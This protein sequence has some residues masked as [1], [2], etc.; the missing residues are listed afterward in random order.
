MANSFKRPL[1]TK[2]P[3]APPELQVSSEGDLV[4]RFD[5]SFRSTLRTKSLL[6]RLQPLAQQ[7]KLGAL[8]AIRFAFG[9]GTIA[10][11]LLVWITIFALLSSS[12][13]DRDKNSRW[14]RE[15]RA[16]WHVVNR[17]IWVWGC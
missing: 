15:C 4:Y 16:Y 12:S 1:L 7:A 3:I 17:S 6:V 9:V 10:T 13:R 2:L 5:R 8:Y 14:G 11:A